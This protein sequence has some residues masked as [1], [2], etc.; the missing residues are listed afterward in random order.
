MSLLSAP[1]TRGVCRF[2][3]R[4][5]RPPSPTI[6]RLNCGLCFQV[7]YHQC[8]T[9][10]SLPLNVIRRP[11]DTLLCKLE[12]SLKCRSCRKGAMRRR[13]T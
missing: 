4:I 11:R 2:R 13:C 1:L 9:R 5:A 7:E 12:T 6:E 8:K 3:R 10:A